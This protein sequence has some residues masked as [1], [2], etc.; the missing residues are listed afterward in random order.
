MP[1]FSAIV[2]FAFLWFLTFLV[3]LP[4]RL[5]TQGEAGSVTPGTP[6][7]A[8][9]NPQMRRRIIVTTIVATLLWALLVW[10]ITSGL[11]TVDDVDVLNRWLRG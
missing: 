10:V 3:V 8:P 11:V 9:A 2:L 4:L 1:V 6:Q 5:Q 7:S